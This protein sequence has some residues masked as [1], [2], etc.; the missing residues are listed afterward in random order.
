MQRAL[1]FLLIGL[2]VA[3]TA[4]QMAYGLHTHVGEV[5]QAVLGPY[6]TDTFSTPVGAAVIYG[7]FYFLAACGLVL[8]ATANR[9]RSTK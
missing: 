4:A 5:L 1:G 3:G 6:V 8:L 7:F 2:A 9:A